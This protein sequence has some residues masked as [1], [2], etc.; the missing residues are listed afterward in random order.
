MKHIMASKY[1]F[2]AYHKNSLIILQSKRKF[3]LNFWNTLNFKPIVYYK[4]AFC[5]D[6]DSLA[7]EAQDLEALVKK[8]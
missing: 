3:I 1:S 6:I 5:G 4:S 7:E 8:T 2:V